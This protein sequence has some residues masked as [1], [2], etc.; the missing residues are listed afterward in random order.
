MD[1]AKTSVEALKASIAAGQA[2]LEAQ[3]TQLDY[4][5]ITAPIERPHRQHAGQARHQRARRRHALPLVTINQMQPIAVAFSLPQAE[6]AALR[7]ALA[8]ARQPRSSRSPAASPDPSRQDRFHR[9]SGRQDQTGTLAAKLEVANKDEALWPGQAVEVALTVETSKNMLA[10]PASAVLPS[11]QG[12]I[13]WV[14]NAR[15]PVGRRSTVTLDRIVGQTAYLS[16]GVKRRRDGRHRRPG[17]DRA[18]RAGQSEDP[19]PRRAAQ[20]K[21][22]R[23]PTQEPAGETGGVEKERSSRRPAAAAQK[24]KAVSGH[25]ARA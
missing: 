15:Q 1:T 2:A 20:Q 19:E 4:L 10:V 23:K 8:Q 5:T 13:V 16:D 7:R 24:Q 11:Q 6:I 14:V 9:Q 22:S 25:E 21:G 3:R 18:G 12:M 17:A